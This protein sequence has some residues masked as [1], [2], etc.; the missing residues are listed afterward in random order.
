MKTM[1]RRFAGVTL[2]E[3]MLVMVIAS[4]LLVMSIKQYEIYRRDA[5]VSQA[6]FNVNQVFYAAALYY[7]ANCRQQWNPTTGPI[8]GTG[9]LDPNNSPSNPYPMPISTLVSQGY[10]AVTLPQSRLINSLGTGGGYIIQFNRTTPDP[11]RT[12]S[13]SSSQTVKTGSIIIWRVQVAVELR[14]SATASQYKNILQADCLST[15][16]GSTVTPC[17]SVGAPPT[18]GTIYAVWERLPSFAA[19]QANSNLWITNATVKEFSQMYFTYPILYLTGVPSSQYPKQ[20]Y[21]CG[22]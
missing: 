16:S 1:R 20:N 3:I 2:L 6:L 17:A 8:A 5:D 4:A 12:V 19:P 7:Q 21:L 22:T 9:A 13:T 11:D 10:L 15:L 18:T 14:K